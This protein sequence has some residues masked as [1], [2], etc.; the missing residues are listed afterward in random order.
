M[1]R[2]MAIKF[3][4]AFV[5]I[6]VFSVGFLGVNPANGAVT[7]YEYNF[8]PGWDGWGA[9]YGV[10]EVGTPTAGPD[11]CHGGSKCAGTVLGGNYPGYTDSRLISATMVGRFSNLSTFSSPSSLIRPSLDR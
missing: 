5:C 9:D 8:E 2:I 6:M 4:I 10:W 3:L 1:K 7:V 11:N